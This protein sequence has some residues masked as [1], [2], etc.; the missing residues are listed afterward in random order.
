MGGRRWTAILILP[1]LSAPGVTA[2]AWVPAAGEAYV[3]LAQ[4]VA[5]AEE[6]FDAEGTVVPYNETTGETVR[7]RSGY[8]YGEV[9]LGRGAALVALLPY[10]RVT[11]SDPQFT[12]PFDRESAAWGTAVLGLRYDLG[13]AVG[14][15]QDGPTRLAVNGTAGLPLGYT[16]NYR[17]AVGPGQVDLALSLDLGRSLWPA[18]GYVQGRLGYRHRTSLYGLS[19]ATA[20]KRDADADGHA[21]LPDADVRR[22][23]GDEFLFGAEAGVTLGPVLV[24]ALLDGTWSATRPTSEPVGAPPESFVRQRLV[25]AGAGLTLYGP[26]GVGVGA[27]VFV[28]AHAQNALRTAEWFVGVEKRF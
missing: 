6:R 14:L 27:Q 28:P 21:C 16:R 22:D 10:R 26:F 23:Y 25:R 3:R 17:P 2:Q 18:P 12:P 11:V 1:L 24:Q 20:C 7:D 9:G 15:A 5:S 19:A 4:G 13:R 8:L